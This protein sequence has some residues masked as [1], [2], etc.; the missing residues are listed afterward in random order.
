MKNIFSCFPVVGRFIKNLDQDIKRF[1]LQ[2]GMAKTL[3]RSHS[4]LLISGQDKATYR[5][6]QKKPVVVIA[7]HPNQSDVFSLLAS[8]PPRKDAF[9]VAINEIKGL[10]PHLDRFLIP[11]FIKHQRP[12]SF[13]ERTLNRLLS[14][15]Y[16]TPRLSPQKAHQKNILSIKKS[17][18]TV[19][20]GGLVAFFPGIREANGHWKPGLGYLLKNL[21]RKDVYIVRVYIKGTSYFD[22]LR[23]FPLLGKFLP[24][25]E[26]YF[27]KP[28]LV[29]RTINLNMNAR[30]IVAGLE[31]QY[32]NWAK[33]I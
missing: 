7:N 10:V 25:M 23:F 14:F 18:R 17:S 12:F 22:Y 5:I 3:S 16:P 6:L 1:G 15:F 11:V 21:N 26:V 27:S 30:E 8:L 19:E 29:Y 32:S 9:I 31:D 24:T 4:K 20:K 13:K 2:T 28:K 33:R